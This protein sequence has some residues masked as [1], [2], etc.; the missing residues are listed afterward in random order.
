[1]RNQEDKIYKTK[2]SNLFSYSKKPLL[3]A[4][5]VLIILFILFV[6]G[7]IIV[8]AGNTKFIES[9]WE[10]AI[11]WMWVPAFLSLTLSILTGMSLF[12]KKNI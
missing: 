4:F 2:I 10:S 8:T 11:S 1:M 12:S 5:I 3:I 6:G 7:A 9:G